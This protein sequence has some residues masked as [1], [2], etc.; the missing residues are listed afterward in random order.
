M[1]KTEAKDITIMSFTVHSDFA[2]EVA[3]IPVA[4]FRDTSGRILG[5]T[6]EHLSTRASQSYP[7]GVSQGSIVVD[8]WYPTN[9][10][11]SRTEVYIA[12][13]WGG[14]LALPPPTGGRC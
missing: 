6:D 3:G 10:D 1:V 5:G 12:R 13:E 11:P 9:A 7:S 8:R 2:N 14:Q 4:I